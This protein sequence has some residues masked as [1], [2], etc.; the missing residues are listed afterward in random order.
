MPF[1]K[2]FYI[3]RSFV[4]N[5]L[6]V[7]LSRNIFILPS[8][9]YRI[10]CW[11]ENSWPIDFLFLFLVEYYSVAFGSPL[12]LKP[13][14]RHL[15]VPRYVL[16]AF[17]VSFQCSGLPVVCTH[18][19]LL[20]LI[21]QWFWASKSIQMKVEPWFLKSFS[22]SLSFSPLVVFVSFICSVWRQPGFLCFYRS[23]T[24]FLRHGKSCCSV[25]ELTGSPFFSC[26]KSSGELLQ[27]VFHFS[28][29]IFQLKNF[30]F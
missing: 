4:S 6:L 19:A 18:V 12:P 28:H 24:L 20:R 26:G 10:L 16:I 23:L 9:F 25:F 17:L 1:F 8:F 15:H 27:S 2:Y 21:S 29:C 30:R 5:S 13:G 11:M 14:I 3:I 22:L 7:L